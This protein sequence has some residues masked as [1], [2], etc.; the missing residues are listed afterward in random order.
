MRAALAALFLA[1][2][3]APTPVDVQVGFPSL[4]TFLYAEFGRLVVY[5]LD[6]QEGLGACPAILDGIE[7]GD[8]GSVDLDSGWQPICSFRNGGVQ[9]PHVPAGP[10]AYVVVARDESNTILLS[11]CRVAEAYEGAPSVMLELYPTPEYAAATGGR[12]LSCAS[13]DD[14]CQRGCR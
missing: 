10:H 2:G 7:A 6:P 12:A 14:K 8:F 13:A 4:E 5:E 11:G 9:L 1:T 3:C